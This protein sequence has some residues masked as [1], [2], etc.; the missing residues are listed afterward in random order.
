VS[1][2]LLTALS[3]P[4]TRHHAP[5]QQ[6]V[7]SNDQPASPRVLSARPLLIPLHRAQARVQALEGQVHAL[8]VRLK[9]L[10]MERTRNTAQLD[11]LT[12]C[13]AGAPVCYY[14]LP[15]RGSENGWHALP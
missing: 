11:L 1:L 3:Q 7:H 9:E 6:D 12:K 4:A 5:R 15:A 13:A 2:M 8:T 14:V 10:E